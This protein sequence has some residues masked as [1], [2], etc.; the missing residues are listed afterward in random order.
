M[1]ASSRPLL[2][3][4][5]LALALCV[6]AAA[7]SEP[8]MPEW[9]R[10][11]SAR[12]RKTY[13]ERTNAAV[14]FE[15]RAISVLRPG[16][17]QEHVRRVVRILRSDGHNEATLHIETSGESRIES[18]HGW[19]ASPDGHTYE[20]REKDLIKRGALAEEFLW[21]DD[22]IYSSFTLPGANPGAVV[23]LEYTVRERT[24]ADYTD[25]HFQE[26]IPVEE[27][28]LKL[29]VPQGWSYRAHWVN[30][31]AV[32]PASNSVTEW[33]WELHD[34]PALD[35]EE[36]H[37]PSM[38]VMAGR[39]QLAFS[40]EGV[41]EPV[42]AAWSSIGKWSAELS[43]PRRQPSP[44]LA[45]KAQQLTAGATSPEQK[46]AQI[47]DF[48]QREI[49][50]V[51]VELGIGGWQPH[52]AAD[53]LHHRYGD[54][55]DKATLMGAMLQSVGIASRNV[56][57][58]NLRGVTKPESPGNTFN[59]MILAVE[60]PEGSGAAYRAVIRAKSGKRYLIFDPTNEFV[61]V[62]NLPYHE[63]GAYALLTGLE[64][65]ELIQLPMLAPSEN[66]IQL[67][68]RLQI[69]DDG[70][71]S[72]Q[73]DLEMTGNHAWGA[74]AN[75]VAETE[76]QRTKSAENFLAGPF[77][78]VALKEMKFGSLSEVNQPMTEHYAFEAPGFLKQTGP[79][80]IFQPC[81]FGH[82]GIRLDWKKRKYPVEL[83]WTTDEVDSYEVR[84]PAGLVVDELPDPVE[85]DVGFASYKSSI[86]AEGSTIR[87][88]RE[89]VVR[90]P[91]VPL[92]KLDQLRKLEETILRDEGASVVVKKKG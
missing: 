25:W 58:Y 70:A 8:V 1:R 2:L 29:T 73:L 22:S 79:L 37:R 72:G 61:P 17:Y 42:F 88:S 23:A 40:P 31:P 41:A 28:H 35:L 39:A 85:I 67:N 76:L 62:G 52:A 50:Y 84:L 75:L 59:H 71:V 77:Q 12:P 32:S 49:R 9:A 86:S 92:E 44:E 65:G 46:V 57:I 6:P 34:V 80:M 90:H 60:L 21:V 87:Y 13:P 10:E 19:C 38:V 91:N 24:F 26:D 53:V 69:A 55:K 63:Q 54:C 16:E 3:L 64:G 4:P 36:R 45:A 11:A 68:G 7:S 51:A 78:K 81:V 66:R 30:W 20:A 48:M 56:D 74:R 27:A 83:G 14:L 18:V 33:S 43:E 89:Y 47:A 5:L 15:E 82:K